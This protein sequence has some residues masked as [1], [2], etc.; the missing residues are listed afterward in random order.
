M[1][2]RKI[3]RLQSADP[4]PRPAV[5]PEVARI[6]QTE[7]REI[8][9]RAILQ[10]AKTIVAERGLDELTLNAA[11]EAAGYSRALP[12]HYFKTKSALVSA[13]VDSI[14]ADYA[15]RVR[16]SLTPGDGIERLIERV[17]FYIDD[18]CRDPVTLRAFQAI[19]A[20][21][22]THP[23]LRPLVE[24]LNRESI[25]GIALLVRRA[26][27]KGD[28]RA[29][30]RPRAEASIIH[31]GNAWSD[32]P[33]VDRSGAREDFDDQGRLDRPH[34]SV[35]R[36]MKE[37]VAR[38]LEYW[39][40]ARGKDVAL[41][42]DGRS[43][44]WADWNDYADGLAQSMIGRGI[45]AGDVVALRMRSRIEWAV[46]AWA[47]GKIDA[48]LLSLDAQ[49]APAEVRRILID[50][51]AA[52]LICDDEDPAALAASLTG[53]QMKLRSTVDVASPG[54]F[55]FWDLF[56]PVAPPRFARAHPEEIA[57]TAIGPEPL[58]AVHIPRPRIALASKSRPPA[59][60]NGASLITLT[61]SHSWAILQLWK[62]VSAGR[63]IVLTPRY[64]PVSALRAI[65]RHGVTEWMDRANTFERL[66]RLPARIVRRFDVR[67][68]KS[69]SVGAGGAPSELKAWLIAT[70]GPIL[71]ESYGVPET[72][73]ITMLPAAMQPARPGT[74]GRP[75]RGVMVEIRDPAGQRLPPNAIGE[76]WARTPGTHRAQAD[77]P[78]RTSRRE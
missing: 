6:S 39:A 26:R 4:A 27:D 53:L 18:A 55:N 69:I 40:R 63:R 54:F 1:T 44:S 71:T 30:A 77:R 21:G 51:D 58:R 34:P 10:A 17:G 62:A 66:A 16:H 7:R 2:A 13:L 45:G 49:L 59:A 3:S 47:I 46:A 22:L 68:L 57:Y 37:P 29:D 76:V 48:C 70:F 8:A 24:R 50:A 25:D 60:D 31:C 74:C 11:G 72:G 19:L 5:A 41:L 73:L 52:A 20:A 64:E 56:P 9:E 35:A 78:R 75:R 14:I 38:S 67:S 12:A 33:V 36:A 42:E 61:L 65:E 23:E 28:I 15:P 32:V 43:L